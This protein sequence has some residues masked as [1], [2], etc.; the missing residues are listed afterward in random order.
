M[1]FPINFQ[2]NATYNSLKSG[3]TIET[4]LRFGDLE[5][6]CLSKID[7]EADF[8]LFGRSIADDLEIDI[9]TGFE[10]VFSTLT[11]GLVA[12]GHSIELET[13]G[14]RFE[15]YVY[16]AESYS[17]NRNLLGRESWLRLI[18]FGLID[19]DNKI[20]LSPNFE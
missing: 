20:F 4:T 5:T 13:L 7:T 15:S 2:K 12:Y 17:V 9:E 8:C 14:L 16:F 19:N 10:Q 1:S 18:K 11:G 6:R 3:I